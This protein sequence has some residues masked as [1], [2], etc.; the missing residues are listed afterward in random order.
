MEIKD[1]TRACPICGQDNGCMLS[2]DCWCHD[3]TVPRELLDTLPEDKK[4]VACICK[5]CIDTY[6]QENTFSPGIKDN[7]NI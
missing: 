3:V 4:K 1:D 6:K 2:K 5:S 7:K